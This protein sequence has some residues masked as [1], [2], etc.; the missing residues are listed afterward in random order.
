[1]EQKTKR[2]TVS[3]HVCSAQI[4]RNVRIASPQT[5]FCSMACKAEYQ[6]WSRPIN[7]EDLRRMYLDEGMSAVDIAKIV[8]RDAKSVWNWLKWDGVPTRPR[9]SD[10]RQHFKKGHDLCVGRVHSAETR[11]KIRQARLDDGSKGL[12]LP[13]GDHVLKGKIGKDHPS[14]QGGV[15][16][17]RNAFY[18]SDEWKSA[19]VA[20]WKRD[21]ATC[22]NCSIKQSD[23]D[24]KKY[25][26]HIHHIKSFARYPELRANPENL[27]L[28]CRPCHLWVHSKKNVENKFNGRSRYEKR[29]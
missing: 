11:E 20:I 19:C 3:C 22:Q 9:G 8:G 2:M 15:T 10:E 1:M 24:R 21:N 6:T 25:A 13:N 7:K 27:V 18:A 5:F 28:L 4:V 12:F 23:V 26:F 14:W 16:P 17:L 29:T